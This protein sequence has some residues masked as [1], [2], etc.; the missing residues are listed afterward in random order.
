[1][2]DALVIKKK[3][4]DDFFKISIEGNINEEFDFASLFKGINK[5]IVIDLEDVKMINYIGFRNFIKSTHVIPDNITIIL[6]QCPSS[7][8]RQLNRGLCFSGKTKIESFLGPYFCESCDVEQNVLI[9][10]EDYHKSG[11]SGA[12][13]NKC[14]SCGEIMGF[15]NI[16]G[17]YFYFLETLLTDIK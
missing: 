11:I 8:V 6:K 7:I 3:E 12:P 17:K 9:N 15:D 10:V 1:M 4:I 13:E 14:A 5:T 2:S 16:E